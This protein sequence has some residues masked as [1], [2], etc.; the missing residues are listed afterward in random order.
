MNDKQLELLNEIKVKMF[1]DPT[2]TL[3]EQ[4][5]R[6]T[7]DLDRIFSTPEGVKDYLKDFE[8]YKH[9][10]VQLAAFGTMFIP[11]V[12]PV[13]STSL[14]LADAAMYLGDDDPYMAGLAIV[15]SLIGV[16]FFPSSKKYSKEF[17]LKTIK[18][19]RVNARLSKE[20][21]ELLIGLAKNSRKI[22]IEA[23]SK[24]LVKILV[25]LPLSKLV[26]FMFKLSRKFPTIYQLSTVLLIIGGVSITYDKLAKFFGILPGN[27]DSEEREVIQNN[28]SNIEEAIVN[29]ILSKTKKLTEEQLDSVVNYLSRTPKL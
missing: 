22:K 15:F 20:E 29:D 7:R 27:L 11:Y 14:E 3:S 10:I 12:G 13:I 26:L 28:Q 19:A 18:K 5:T 17:I 23:L 24:L 9:E 16:P 6:F 8:P 4:E 25:K 2:K 1:Y 21:S